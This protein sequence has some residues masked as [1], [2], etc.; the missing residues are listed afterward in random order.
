MIYIEGL[1]LTQWMIW[2]GR[3]GLRELY[4]WEIKENLNFFSIPDTRVRKSWRWCW[5]VCYG[6]ASELQEL[7]WQC[8]YEPP[9]SSLGLW[10][11]MPS[12][13]EWSPTSCSRWEECKLLLGRCQ[14]SVSRGK[15]S[16]PWEMWPAAIQ[17]INNLHTHFFFLFLFFSFFLRR[18]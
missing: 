18:E 15:T 2:K 5:P 11:V 16:L 9:I 7:C 13:A 14:L 1:K 4:L 3:T 10:A 8:Q 6:C 12:S 17:D